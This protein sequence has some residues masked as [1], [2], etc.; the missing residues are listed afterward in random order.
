M[1]SNFVL[2]LRRVKRYD[3]ADSYHKPCLTRGVAIVAYTVYR[4]SFVPFFFSH[5]PYSYP[6]L[7]VLVLSALSLLQLKANRACFLFKA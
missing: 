7:L 6:D 5:P 3:K 1:N 2:I 4:S